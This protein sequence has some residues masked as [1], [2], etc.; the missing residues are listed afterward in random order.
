ME[1]RTV[2]RAPMG[3]ALLWTLKLFVIVAIGF[4]AL[5]LV[6]MNLMLWAC[7]R[8]L[9]RWAEPEQIY[10]EYAFAYSLLPGDVHATDLHLTNQDSVLQWGLKLD[11]VAFHIELGELF[12]RRVHMTHVRGSGLVFRTRL[13]LTPDEANLPAAQ[14]LPPVEGYRD[15]PILDA[16]VRPTP[17]EEAYRLWSAELDD[18]DTELRELWIH[19]YRFTGDARVKGSFAI[20]PLRAVAIDATGIT[21]HEGKVSL[22]EHVV[23]RAL[24][25]SLVAHIDTFDPLVVTLPG[26]LRHLRSRVDLTAETPGAA[27]LSFYRP[28]GAVAFA[29]GSGAIKLAAA[30]DRGELAEGSEAS[31]ETAHLLLDG[32]DRRVTLGAEIAAKVARAGG[33]TPRLFASLRVPEARV[34]RPRA[35]GASLVADRVRLD[36]ETRSADLADLGLAAVVF[37]LPTA[38]VG[39]LRLLSEARAADTLALLGGFA[40]LAAHIELDGAGKGG[41]LLRASARGARVRVGE[42]VMT[43]D[44]S[45]TA[46][47]RGLDLGT[48]T[49]RIPAAKIEAK[50]LRLARRNSAEATLSARLQIDSARVSLGDRPGFAAGLKIEGSDAAALF[51]YAGLRGPLRWAA[52]LLDVHAFSGEAGITAAGGAFDLDVRTMKSGSVEGRGHLRERGGW[53]TGAFVL[54][55]GLMTAGVSLGRGGISITPFPGADWLGRELAKALD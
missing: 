43:A 35:S 21:V 24:S 1:P 7:L 10:L 22:A 38:R 55:A 40:E 16:S 52:D 31:I 48:R 51:E 13:K 33:P 36:V 54:R 39:D 50:S 27:F 17:P 26:L 2:A 25:G 6:L 37:D 49:A 14:A 8:P 5:Y 19:H 46:E 32:L 20:Q 44:L 18:V 28:E 23:A 29:D 3:A 42:G 9:L 45:A 15:P 47:V 34:S 53:R 11:R 41:G 30:I 4:E 12:S